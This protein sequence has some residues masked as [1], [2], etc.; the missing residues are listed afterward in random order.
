MQENTVVV[1]VKPLEKN[2]TVSKDE[3]VN[4]RI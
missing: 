4:A 1:R 2:G 3:S